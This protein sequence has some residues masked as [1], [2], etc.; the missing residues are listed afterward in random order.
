MVPETV[1]LAVLIIVTP[2]SADNQDTRIA[3][4]KRSL[5]QI[6]D[7]NGCYHGAGLAVVL[8]ITAVHQSAAA[9]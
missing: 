9:G 2:P 8:T 6:T 7:R 5:W 4:R 1:R 3:R